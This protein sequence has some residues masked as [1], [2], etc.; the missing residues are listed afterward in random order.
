MQPITPIASL[1]T[2]RIRV[3]P[4]RRF[5]ETDNG[6]PFFWL[7]DTAWELFHRLSLEDAEFYLLNRAEKRFTVIQ[8]VVLAEFDGLGTPNVYGEYPFVGNDLSFPNE[9]Y[10]AHVDRVIIVAARLGLYIG[11]LP[12]WGD[13]VVAN[14]WGVGPQVFTTENA[15]SYGKWLGK[16][17]AGFP[18]IIW[19]LGGDRPAVYSGQDYRPIWRAMSSGIDAGT[20]ELGLKTYHPMGGYS[21]SAW[22]HEESWLDMNMMQSGHGSGHDVA[23]WDMITADY[24][25][26]PNK[27]VLDGEPNYEDHPV[28]PWPEWDPA[29]GY[30]RDDD[31]RKQIYRSV[32]AGGCGVTYGH[33]AVWQFYQP[34]REPINHPDRIWREALDR[35]GASQVQFLRSLMESRPYFTRIPDQGMLVSNPGIGGE[36]VQVTRDLD[37]SYALVYL[38]TSRSVE[39]SMAQFRA[40]KVRASWYDPRTGTYVK[41]GSFTTGEINLTFSPPLKGPDWVLVVDGD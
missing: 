20:G 9:A 32:F 17:Y 26:H 12:T 37:G 13:K 27:P 24:Q 3:S 33:H 15:Y 7:G 1:L 14:M 10:F 6:K 30:F 23:V 2:P 34:D 29:N 35:P 22:L 28:N 31:V 40:R 19:I 36:H 38:P 25:R 4:N 5:L 39:I 41:T 16:R 21:S 18:N 11:L 8:A